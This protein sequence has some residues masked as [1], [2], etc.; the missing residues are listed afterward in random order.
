MRVSFSSAPFRSRREWEPSTGEV[1][2]RLEA[3]RCPDG[4]YGLRV[5]AR[6]VDARKGLKGERTRSLSCC[7]SDDWVESA[8]R[9]VYCLSRKRKE[10]GAR[11]ERIVRCDGEVG[12]LTPRWRPASNPVCGLTSFLTADAERAR[13]VLS[14]PPTNERCVSDAEMRNVG[15]SVLAS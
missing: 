5:A 3:G 12:G 14:I 4:L 1:R 13:D 11:V 9:R 7:A 2:A 10:T 6:G 15:L 8:D